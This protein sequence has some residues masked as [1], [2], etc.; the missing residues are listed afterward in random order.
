[1]LEKNATI[2]IVDDD[3]SVRNGLS[4]LLKS[5][6]YET[7]EYASA[8]EYLQNPAPIESYGCIILDLKMPGLS[9]LDM[10]KKLNMLET[11][12]PVIFITGHGDISASV[13]AMKGGAIDFLTK[14]FEEKDL[15]SAISSALYRDEQN[16]VHLAAKNKAKEDLAF[17]TPREK[18]ILTYIITG[19]LNK[20]IA[21]SLH[22]S[23]KT[24]K[25][26]RG[27]VMEKMN[28]NSVAELV[29]KADTAGVKPARK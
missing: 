26:H 6:G 10:Q 3:F 15:L 2:Y 20:Q 12:L 27:R 23:E 13:K 9:G 5:F 28:V 21:I 7:K 11:S 22:I 17:L 25:V 14:P 24:V 4:R 18:E 29:R 8:N 19:M 1:M 16:K